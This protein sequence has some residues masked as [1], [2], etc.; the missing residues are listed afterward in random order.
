MHGSLTVGARAGLTGGLFFLLTVLL[1]V[2]TPAQTQSAPSAPVREPPTR[3]ATVPAARAAPL[4]PVSRLQGVDYVSARALADGLDLKA[5]WT[6]PNAALTLSDARGVRFTFEA[7][8]HDIYFDGARVHLGAPVLVS[9]GDLWVS[10][11]DVIKIVAPLFRPADHAAL[12]PAITTRMIVLDPGHGGID[13]G[14]E[15]RRVGINEKT[16]ALDVARRL[17]KLLELQGWRVLLTRD[18]DT[19]LAKNKKADLALRTVVANQSKAELFISIH[20]N[21]APES[22]SGVETYSMTPQFM[23]STGA[24]EQGDDMT[25][26][27]FPGNRFDYANLLLG[28]KLHRALLA[29]LKTPDRGF[30]RGRWG[31]LRMLDCPG[32]LVE[33]DYLSNDAA[34][35]RVATLAFRQ[36][37]AEALADGVRDYAAAVQALR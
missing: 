35:R 23:L 28:E 29:Q 34:A 31:V 22:I 21:S 6:K 33:C 25:K 4:W 37:I 2:Q 11:L 36:Q 26:Q 3:P 8:Q 13:P 19:E 9:K 5:R 16:M 7:S 32:V 27:A 18:E 14:T 15:N 17:K 24:S 20:F 12:L 1:S 30:K 10:K